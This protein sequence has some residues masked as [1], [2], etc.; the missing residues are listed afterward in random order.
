M[1]FAPVFLTLHLTAMNM[2]EEALGRSK[3]CFCVPW[4]EYQ[5]AWGRGGQWLCPYPL[6]TMGGKGNLRCMALK[7]LGNS[8][9][10]TDDDVKHRAGLR[11]WR[12]TTWLTILLPLMD[13]FHEGCLAEVREGNKGPLYYASG[14]PTWGKV[15]DVIPYLVSRLGTRPYKPV[16]GHQNHVLKSASFPPR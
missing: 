9:D 13:R 15:G 6:R 5:G 4:G 12:Q 16:I 1:Y 2:S 8:C 11:H 10:P 3:K 14:Y 7:T